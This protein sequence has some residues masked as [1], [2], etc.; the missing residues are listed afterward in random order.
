M[1][2]RP[3]M[4]KEITL[5][6]VMYTCPE[7]ERTFRDTLQSLALSDWS[8]DLVTVEDTADG[9]PSLARQ[10][11]NFCL[12]VVTCAAVRAD[13]V[14]LAEDDLIFNRYVEHNTRSWLTSFRP[15]DVCSLYQLNS[16]RSVGNQAVV[17]SRTKWRWIAEQAAA[18]GKETNDSEP[19][20]AW[21]RRIV[22]PR[23][24]RV[25]RPSLVQHHAHRSTVG[26]YQHR[27]LS[28]DLHWRTP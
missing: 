1:Q 20:D 28:F 14:V 8:G 16:I 13:F 18:R 19:T 22:D 6:M 9:P 4:P 23:K 12:A 2:A 17:A 25:H 24:F 27:S 26:H 3:K 11:R 15:N 5:A 10:Y 21:L 7:R